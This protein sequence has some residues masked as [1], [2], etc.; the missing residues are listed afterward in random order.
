MLG[1][2][3]L[4]SHDPGALHEATASKAGLLSTP[5]ARA[6]AHQYTHA[7]GTLEVYWTGEEHE[8]ALSRRQALDIEEYFGSRWLPYLAAHA[9]VAF[10]LDDPCNPG[11]EAN[12][13]VWKLEVYPRP[14]L[15]ILCALHAGFIMLPPSMVD[16][17]PRGMRQSHA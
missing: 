13:P 5:M 17:W 4:G 6:P 3:Q 2:T 12:P 11:G 15:N 8:R 14:T 16:T 7:N 1:G 9:G 10:G